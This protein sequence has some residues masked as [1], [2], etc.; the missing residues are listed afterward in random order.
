MRIL[1]TCVVIAFAISM[2][3]FGAAEYQEIKSKDSSVPEIISDR[4]VL[5]IPCEYTQEQLME[6]LEAY[7]DKDGDLTSEIMAGSFSR[8]IE[9]GVCDLR[10]IVFDSSQQPATLTRRVKFTDYHS[11]RFTLTQPLVYMED[12][13]NYQESMNRIGATDQ[14]DGDLTSRIKQTD[15]DVKYQTAG[16]YQMTVEVS[17][18]YGDTSTVA[19]P[20]HV[21]EAASHTLSVQL[22]TP[23]VYL[24]VGEGID[25]N[26]YVAGVYDQAGNISA[27]A[28][29]AESYVDTQTPGVYEIYY[30]ADDGQGNI[31]ETWLTVV[32]QE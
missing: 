25:P 20:I 3:V 1:R 28:V 11:P 14:L 19:L 9:K 4:E 30:R 15:S 7:D 22:T 31:G 18:H 29:G 21:L 12:A 26:A 32:V 27:A 13:G 6:G 16:T 5:E 2:V 23:I 24:G 10:Y 8:F 17:N